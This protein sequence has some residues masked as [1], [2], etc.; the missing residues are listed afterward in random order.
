MSKLRTDLSLKRY[1][2]E[3][4][5][6][7]F[8]CGK[9]AGLQ[10]RCFA[11]GAKSF[12]YRKSIKVKW[13]RLPLENIPRCHWQRRVSTPR[14]SLLVPKGYS[15]KALRT[16]IRY[17]DTANDISK[18]LSSDAIVADRTS[19][20]SNSEYV[21]TFG[22]VHMDWYEKDGNTE[23]IR[24]RLGSISVFRKTTSPVSTIAQWS[25]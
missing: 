3:G 17:S 1:T 10:V 23:S 14:H 7:L 2:H 22:D 19:V 6:R 25:I 12:Y 24:L 21:V 8:S 5:P 15:S 18:Y 20:Q 4:A 13:Y 11:S 9:V 16:A